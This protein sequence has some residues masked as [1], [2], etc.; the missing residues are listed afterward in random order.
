M[1]YSSTFTL[2]ESSVVHV[3]LI[4]SNQTQPTVLS[5]TLAD[6]T[7]PVRKRI[8]SAGKRRQK[9]IIYRVHSIKTILF[10]RGDHGE[11]NGRGLMETTKIFWM[12]DKY[13]RKTPL[14]KIYYR[15]KI[16]IFYS[17]SSF[18]RTTSG[19]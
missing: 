15:K 18:L 17:L 10:D 1:R 8:E 14:D 5:D 9:Y 19:L 16:C 11:Y 7:N 3:A 4:R 6:T 2:A 13:L 12:Q